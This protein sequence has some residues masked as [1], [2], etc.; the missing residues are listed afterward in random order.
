MII[1]NEYNLAAMW[2]ETAILLSAVLYNLY[3]VQKRNELSHPSNEYGLTR[4]SVLFDTESAFDGSMRTSSTSS[5][6]ISL[7][8]HVIDSTLLIPAYIINLQNTYNC[9]T[10][11]LQIQLGQPIKEDFITGRMSF[12]I[13]QS[14]VLM[15]WR[16][17][18]Y[19]KK[20]F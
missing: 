7:Q 16:H 20:Q 17:F 12:Q 13:T 18:N 10:A 14:T 3:Q 19:K 9:L 2:N 1:I 4:G 8:Q 6:H 5:N 15:Y 11:T